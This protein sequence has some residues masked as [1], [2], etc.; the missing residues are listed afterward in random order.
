MPHFMKQWMNKAR[1]CLENQMVPQEQGP[2]FKV[3]CWGENEKEM[4]TNWTIWKSC[5]V[6]LNSIWK[7]KLSTEHH[8][9]KKVSHVK[10]SQKKS[11]VEPSVPSPK[12]TTSLN[13]NNRGKEGL[14]PTL[15]QAMGIELSELWS[16]L[17]L[18]WLQNCLFLCYAWMSFHHIWHLRFSAY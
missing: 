16:R 18:F 9:L 6:G 14:I 1:K 5:R 2:E 4:I 8:D 7:R 10:G 15:I 12:K 17:F 13:Q 11:T 3:L